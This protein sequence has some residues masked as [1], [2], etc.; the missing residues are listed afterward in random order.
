MSQKPSSNASRYWKLI[1]GLLISGFFLWRTL[2]GFHL[3]EL[4]DVHF[5]HPAWILGVLLFISLDYLIRSYRWYLMLRRYQ[6]RFTACFRVLL[7]SLAAN[8]ILPFRIGDF[9][10]IFAYAPDVNA[11]SSAVL[12]TVVLERLLDTVMLLGFF[13]VAVSGL[14]SHFGSFTFHGYGIAETVRIALVFA[15]LC[16]CLLLF[17]TH[18]LHL[19]TQKLVARFGNHP[20]TR[21][22]GEW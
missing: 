11:S 15:A 3:D 14:E 10:R 17:G 12:S 20:R 18:L 1:P 22:L 13:A 5:G 4:R 9:L 6:A 16:L 7:T 19:L 8:N 2:R 21:S